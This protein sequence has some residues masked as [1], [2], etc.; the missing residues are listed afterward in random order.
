MGALHAFAAA[1]TKTDLDVELCDDR[2]DRR[3]VRLKLLESLCLAN[4]NMTV[5]THSGGHVDRAVH[6]IRSRSVIRMVTGFTSRFLF[7]GCG[8]PAVLP[9]IRGF[10][11]L[12]LFRVEKWSGLAFGLSVLRVELFLKILHLFAQGSQLHFQSAALRALPALSRQSIHGPRF[13]QSEPMHEYL[14][15]TR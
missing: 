3:D 9:G 1:E 14:F 11:F 6:V 12:R 8:V 2:R 5:R 10:E 15:S 13:T 4:R 7:R